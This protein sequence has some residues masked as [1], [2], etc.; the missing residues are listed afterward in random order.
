MMHKIVH[1]FVDLERD[2]LITILPFTTARNP[3]LK[4]SKPT[5]L[6]SGRCKFLC[7]RSINVRN[8]LSEE[9]RAAPSI[10][11]LK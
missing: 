6:S 8:F 5:S 2:T 4:I 9:T 7:V 1:N 11:R 10:S 3:L